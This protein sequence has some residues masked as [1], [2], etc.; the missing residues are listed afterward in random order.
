M[1][2]LVAAA[3]FAAGPS[4]ATE[5]PQ[6]TVVENF[7]PIELRDY[8][9]MIVAEVTVEGDRGRAI[10]QGFGLLADYIFGNNLAREK[11]AMTTPVTQTPAAKAQTPAM[12]GS[13]MA[14]ANDDAAGWKVRFMMPAAYT[15]ETL[16]AP[17]N[18]AVRLLALPAQRSVVL[19]FSGGRG[20]PLLAAK[21]AELRQF[22]ERRGL[23]ALGL[24]VFA[25]YDPPWTPGFFRRNEVSLAI[26]G[27]TAP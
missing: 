12:P 18:P 24:P 16:P 6:Y 8:A 13:A 20:E 22:V 27:G 17:R 1:L 19:R 10:N 2:A 15:L 25:F 9:P 5:Q 11:V 14:G 3:I 23:K 4:M 21:E 26:A 7:G